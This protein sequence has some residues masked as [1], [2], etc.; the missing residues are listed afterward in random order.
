[1]IQGTYYTITEVAA[2][3][4]KDRHT[5]ARWLKKGKIQGVQRV[6]NMALIPEEEVKKV[7]GR[8]YLRFCVIFIG[9]IVH[10]IVKVFM[11]G[12]GKT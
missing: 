2:L 1:M 12:L 6:G 8:D 4:K 7:G 5:I 3:L 9:G 10:Y 11:K